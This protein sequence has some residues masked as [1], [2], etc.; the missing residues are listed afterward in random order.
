[1]V[2]DLDDFK[3]C[4]TM[5]SATAGDLALEMFATLRSRTYASSH[6]LVRYGGD[7]FLIVMPNIPEQA[8]TEKAAI[9]MLADTRS[10]DSRLLSQHGRYPCR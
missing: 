1:M 8:V 9:N 4:T 3:L 6:T 7:E 5:R 2:V 10:A